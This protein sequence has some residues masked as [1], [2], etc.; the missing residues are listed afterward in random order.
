[1]TSPYLRA[2]FWRSLWLPILASVAVS[3]AV[4][5]FT[6][7]PGDTAVW[8]AVSQRAMAGQGMYQLTGFS[9]PPLFGYWCMFLGGAAH[10]L[11]FGP[12]SLGGP[13]PRVIQTTSL[14][15]AGPMIVT[16]PLYT[17]LTKAP[18]IAA[19]LATG[20]FIWRIALQISGDH[21][22]ARRGFLLWALNP[23]VIL[24]SAVHGQIDALAA[25]GIA[26]AICFALEDR[27][28][29]AG[30]AIAL[31]VGGDLI[32]IFV[33]AP[34]LGYAASR[35]RFATIWRLAAGGVGAGLV[36][37]LPVL[38]SGMIEGVFTRTSLGTAVGGLGL[39]GLFS[40][41]FLSGAQTFLVTHAA[42]VGQCAD[43]VMV[44]T[45]VAVGVWLARHGNK[46]SLVKGCFVAIG[47]V[48][49]VSTVVNPQYLL[50]ILPFF[51]LGA[52][53]LLGGHARRFQI[54]AG[55]VA[56]GGV[57]Y[58]V[59]IVGWAELLAPASFAFGWPAAATIPALWRALA[60][61]SGPWPLPPLLYQK[62]TLGGTLCVL[63]GGSLAA[64]EALRGRRVTRGSADLSVTSESTRHRRRA[65]ALGAATGLAI[66][67]IEV[68][69]LLTPSLA[70][71][72]PSSFKVLVR[73]VGQRRAKI[74]FTAARRERV[75]VFAV[76]NRPNI[77]QIVVY[78]SPDRPDSGATNG[79]VVGTEQTLSYVLPDVPIKTASASSLPEILS[80]TGTGTLLLDAA[81]TLPDT[82][83]G[84]GRAGL[85]LSW[86][87]AGGI[88]AFAGDRPGYYAVGKGP[89][90]VDPTNHL[91]SDVQVLGAR[92]IL[93]AGV[94]AGTPLWGAVPNGHRSTWATALGLQ[95]TD[96]AIPL[97][98]RDVLLHHGVVLGL[99]VRRDNTS[100]AYV[101]LG[102]GGVVD[103]AGYDYSAPV[104]NDVAHLVIANFF[105]RLGPSVM[106]QVGSGRMT[107]TVSVP[108]SARAIEVFATATNPD[109]V[110][111]RA[112]R[113][114]W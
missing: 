94:V 24:E 100:E 110:W 21:A 39:T 29:L 114:P 15:G 79:T 42:I 113:I 37:L 28:E 14:I 51:A 87:R 98:T 12:A 26:A 27:W 38:G 88:L 33:V 62:L 1:M 43:L 99:L 104:A 61:A 81:G 97:S 6:S 56:L 40:L 91:A 18:M 103:F 46:L 4:A 96:D 66:V 76:S 106:T 64:V 45:S 82:V 105:S 22:V 53:G 19:D 7:L 63:A 90:L 75:S 3:L 102:K 52:A 16:T 25:C 58:L 41:S 48:L 30:V 57:L 55:L 86:I 23:L 71:V 10:L 54:A 49:G 111:A 70:A 92:A 78:Y 67:A 47:V 74:V 17:L 72:V 34:L 5:P 13:D 69:G 112:R 84:R 8:L 89:S 44:L 107:L 65:A 50:W 109:V 95:Y 20:Y 59:A 101:P 85:L 80:Q 35:K 9:Y 36:L 2:G 31:G 83:W 60:R 11:G 68:L 108:R 77:K 32:P 93:P 73:H